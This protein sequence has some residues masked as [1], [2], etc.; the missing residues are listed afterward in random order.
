MTADTAAPDRDTRDDFYRYAREMAVAGKTY[1]AAVVFRRAADGDDP[2]HI[3]A[4]ARGI[5]WAIDALRARSASD[6]QFID[7]M[8][9][10]VRDA[11]AALPAPQPALHPVRVFEEE[12]AQS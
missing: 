5:R 7:I 11:E 6:H 2:A 3:E 1:V 10:A 8:D 9:D 4:A 12:E